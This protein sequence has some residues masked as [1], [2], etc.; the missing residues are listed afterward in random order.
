MSE[1]VCHGSIVAGEEIAVADRKIVLIWQKSVLETRFCVTRDRCAKVK[2]LLF[3]SVVFRCPRGG[4]P[5]MLC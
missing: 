2:L 1:G 5:I 4:V 3:F